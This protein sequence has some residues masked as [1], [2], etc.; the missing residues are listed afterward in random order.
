MMVLQNRIFAFMH[1]VCVLYSPAF[2]N[3]LKPRKHKIP[4]QAQR[5]DNHYNQ[6]ASMIIPAAARR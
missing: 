4:E 5:A 1:F 3:I 2:T 6:E